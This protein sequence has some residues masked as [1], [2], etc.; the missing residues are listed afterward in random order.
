MTA[1]V[2]SIVKALPPLGSR[3]LPKEWGC[4]TSECD[5]GETGTRKSGWLLGVAL[6]VWHVYLFRR[7]S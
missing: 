1:S 4:S 2:Q 7:L 6:L 5:S 3:S